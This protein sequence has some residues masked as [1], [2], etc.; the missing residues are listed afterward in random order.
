M[1]SLG[2]RVLRAAMGKAGYDIVRVAKPRP[3]PR[4]QFSCTDLSEYRRTTNP[5]PGMISPEAAE[6]LYAIAV[7]QNV[8][9][10]ILEIGSWQGKSTSYLARAVV[11]SKNGHMFAVDHFMGNVGKE[12]L[13]FVNEGGSANLKAQFERNMHTLNLHDAVTLLPYSSEQAYPKLADR[14]FRLLF[15]DGDHTEQGVKKDIELF[16]P[17]VRAGGVVVFD[18]FN[19][20]SP[21]VVLAAE[22]WVKLQCPRS[23]FVSGNM[24]VCKI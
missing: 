8:E 4:V 15:I 23:S 18:D 14:V 11:D 17:L 20:T 6:L 13:Y 21:G 10:D 16:C 1:L 24:L 9:G 5:I 7:V 19:N 3:T 12:N 22:Q 2:K